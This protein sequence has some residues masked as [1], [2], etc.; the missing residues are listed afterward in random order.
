MSS[1]LLILGCAAVGL[2]VWGIVEGIKNP[3]SSR[4]GTVNPYGSDHRRARERVRREVQQSGGTCTER[5]CLRRTRRIEPFEFFH[6]AHDHRPGSKRTYLGPSHPEC[7]LSEAA[8]RR[9]AQR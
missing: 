8:T 2:F 4:P 5:V 3:G 9:K 1:V 7:N 6:L